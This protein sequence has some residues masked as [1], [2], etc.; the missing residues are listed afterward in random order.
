M[1][2]YRVLDLLGKSIGVL[3]AAALPASPIGENRAILIDVAVDERHGRRRQY[4]LL[5]F[6]LLGLVTFDDN[7]SRAAIPLRG[8]QMLVKVQADE[9][10]HPDRSHLEDFDRDSG[11]GEEGGRARPMLAG[12]ELHQF[13]A[14][15]EESTNVLE[16][17]Q[18]P[19]SF[20]VLRS[21][22][23]MPGIDPPHDF[24][25]RFKPALIDAKM[26]ARNRLH[27]AAYVENSQ[28]FVGAIA[29]QKFQSLCEGVDRDQRC[30]T[31]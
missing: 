5:R 3:Y 4:N 27:R 6:V 26:M 21:Q 2:P 12:S 8:S 19:Q 16:I 25:H 9:I 22:A 13:G 30:Q 15:V 14:E 24:G 11:L 29:Q 23:P 7:V 1:G 10:P 28:R 31:G 20:A 17:V 18:R